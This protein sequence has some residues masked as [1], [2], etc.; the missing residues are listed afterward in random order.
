MGKWDAPA[1][2]AALAAGGATYISNDG[3]PSA[4]TQASNVE[5]L[6]SQGANVLIN[7]ARDGTAIK[8]GCGRD[9]AWCHGQLMT[10]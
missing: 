7:L 6:I 10:G 3:K 4:E 9:R 5:N 2:Q 8:I 1:I